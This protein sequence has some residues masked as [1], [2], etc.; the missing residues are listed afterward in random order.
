MH[1]HDAHNM[2]VFLFLLTLYDVDSNQHVTIKKTLEWLYDEI[3][4]SNSSVHS[5][6][7]VIKN[8]DMY[9]QTAKGRMLL[10]FTIH[11]FKTKN[12]NIYN[13]VYEFTTNMLDIDT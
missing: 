7:Q 6:M 11:D 13:E 9:L 2:D 8:F 1:R 3:Y 5:H 12:I 4:I 10:A